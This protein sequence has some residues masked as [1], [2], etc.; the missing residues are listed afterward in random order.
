MALDDDSGRTGYLGLTFADLTFAA[1]KSV[2]WAVVESESGQPTGRS[3]V[4]FR[5]LPTE[6]R[7]CP[8][9]QILQMRLAAPRRIIGPTV[10]PFVVLAEHLDAQG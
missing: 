1:V 3:F 5:R 2:Q 4:A 8:A 10:L 6:N 7:Q 9:I